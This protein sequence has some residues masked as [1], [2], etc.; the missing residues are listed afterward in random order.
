MPGPVTREPFQKKLKTGIEKIDPAGIE[1]AAFRTAAQEAF[2]GDGADAVKTKFFEDATSTAE[3]EVL[4]D[5][6]KLEGLS[7]DDIKAVLLEVRRHISVGAHFDA[8]REH[9]N[10]RTKAGWK[11]WEHIALNAKDAAT[12]FGGGVAK[13]VRAR[14]AAARGD[15]AQVKALFEGAME[16]GIMRRRM[17]RYLELGGDNL[18]AAVDGLKSGEVFAHKLLDV[19]SPLG[20]KYDLGLDQIIAALPIEVGAGKMFSV[21]GLGD[22]E[23]PDEATKQAIQHHLKFVLRTEIIKLVEAEQLTVLSSEEYN[24]AHPQTTAQKAWQVGK[25]I[26]SSGT[27]WGM[28]TRTG[29][30]LA[31]GGMLT[32]AGLTGGTAILGGMVIGAGVGAYAAYKRETIDARKRLTRRKLEAALGAV[33]DEMVK[34]ASVLNQA[35]KAGVKALQD[36]PNEAAKISAL[37]LAFKA[38]SDAQ[39]R[40]QQ[41]RLDKQDYISFGVENRFQAQKQL[42]DNI[43]KALAAISKAM[44]E[45]GAAKTASLRGE[46]DTIN[47]DNSTVLVA[48][49]EGFQDTVSADET[50][51][52]RRAMMIGGVA[53]GFG[54][55]VARY[56]LDAW[57][58]TGAAETAA[59]HTVTTPTAEAAAGAVP[60]APSAAEQIAGSQPI[61][62]AGK[63]FFF[64]K[65]A[66]HYMIQ[67][68]D[69]KLDVHKLIPDGN[70]VPGNDIQFSRTLE[71][72]QFHGDAL[73]AVQ[74]PEGVQLYDAT[75]HPVGEVAF[76]ADTVGSN[77]GITEQLF[78]DPEA[79]KLLDAMGLQPGEVQYDPNTHLFH[80]PD[81][82]LRDAA[83]HPEYLGQTAGWRARRMEFILKALAEGKTGESSDM[84]VARAERATANLLLKSAS[85]GDPQAAFD[86]AFGKDASFI[87][88]NIIPWIDG[89]RSRVSGRWMKLVTELKTQQFTPGQGGIGTSGE[90]SLQP[91]D[92]NHAAGGSVTTVPAG[93]GAVQGAAA[94]ADTFQ[95]F[96]IDQQTQRMGMALL[97]IVG[98]GVWAYGVKDQVA[99]DPARRNEFIGDDEHTVP[100][101]Q[102]KGIDDVVADA[103]AAEAARVAAAA[104]EAARVAAAEAT[105]LAGEKGPAIKAE[106]NAFITD[107]NTAATKPTSDALLAVRT[108]MGTALDGTHIDQLIANAAGIDTLRTKV[109]EAETLLAKN[110]AGLQYQVI[111]AANGGRLAAWITSQTEALKTGDELKAKFEAIVAGVATKITETRKITDAAG[112]DKGIPAATRRSELATELAKL[113]LPN[114]VVELVPSVISDGGSL[115]ADIAKAKQEAELAIVVIDLNDLIGKNGDL[116]KAVNERLTAEGCFDPSDLSLPVPTKASVVTRLL[117]QMKVKS[118]GK[119]GAAAL[120]EMKLLNSS[121]DPFDTDEQAEL[122]RVL[123]RLFNGESDIFSK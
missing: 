73:Q 57:Q 59:A 117:E 83:G 67:L 81:D 93:E 114:R 71:I 51:R 112:T 23:V 113:A 89:T 77:G 22:I 33:N 108:A 72:P 69:G 90:V 40:L 14:E 17:K 104:A 36:A 39:Q 53:G 55:L 6:V 121:M 32:A 94:A 101:T 91:F 122:K 78:A 7:P 24:I 20:Q 30:R 28:A 118:S 37:K 119:T 106:I 86:E 99:H 76:G 35:L 98:A 47:G 92:A 9:E 109:A 45:L 84:I 10:K 120:R 19:T 21:D 52:R 66:D 123:N 42:L 3:L 62:A 56:A 16:L 46:L 87:Q 4:L 107:A 105:R 43:E 100:E 8:T 1:L 25:G 41:A 103:Q 18:K 95:D 26:V 75:G 27:F 54:S 102:L 111:D 88:K 5:R 115:V 64:T 29:G 68:H 49:K 97:G 12:L 61:T 44:E 65:G 11:F 63:S 70:H 74:T 15:A 2:Q 82:A 96:A 13:D 85:H 58:G 31:F 80:I 48:A 38:A 110:D 60:D 79:S 34:P 116:R 50:R